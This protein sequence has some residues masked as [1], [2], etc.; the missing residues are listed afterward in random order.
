MHRKDY[1][2]ARHFYKIAAE[3][4]N[5]NAM[6]NLGLMDLNG[7][8]LP[9]PNYQSAREWF[10]KALTANPSPQF[11][12]KIEKGLS[13]LEKILQKKRPVSESQETEPSLQ[14]SKQPPAKK[15]K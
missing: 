12:A 15:Q 7:Q 3:L 6:Y 10:T 13:E 5:L 8:G 4:G 11:K 2:T 9:A 1:Q 14:S